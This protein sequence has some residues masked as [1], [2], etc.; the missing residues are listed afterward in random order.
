LNHEKLKNLDVCVVVVWLVREKGE[1]EL[2]TDFSVVLKCM[3][4]A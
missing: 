1:G 4:K 2:A 3:G